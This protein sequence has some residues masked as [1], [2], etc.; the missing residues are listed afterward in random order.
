MQQINKN[1]RSYQ[2]RINS[3]TWFG[4]FNACSCKIGKSLFNKQQGWKTLKPVQGFSLFN[5]GNT[6]F[7]LIELLVVVLIIGILAAVALPQYQTAV[8]K[9]RLSTVMNNVKTIGNAMDLYYL[10]NGTYPEDDDANQSVSVLDISINGCAPGSG[11]TFLC[12]KESYDYEDKGV[13][14]GFLN[15][16]AGVG[17]VYFTAHST[18]TWGSPNTYQCWA[19]SSNNVANRVCKSMGTL[20]GTNDWRSGSGANHSYAAWNVYTIN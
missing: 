4:I 5:N 8:L 7:T 13:I 19:D 12:S 10:A 18:S 17:Y 14:G 9:S 6:G 3:R 20:A 11:G 2:I 15:N 1:L 16:F